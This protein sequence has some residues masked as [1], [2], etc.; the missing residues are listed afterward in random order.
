MIPLRSGLSSR[1]TETVPG[2]PFDGLY[3][4]GLPSLNSRVPR[5]T[6]PESVNVVDSRFVTGKI[7]DRLAL[8]FTRYY[9]RE[10]IGVKRIHLD[11]GSVRPR[12]PVR[13]LK[14]GY[15]RDGTVWMVRNVDRWGGWTREISSPVQDKSRNRSLG[16]G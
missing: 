12:S 1:G 14:L 6:G 5:L 7:R 3:K 11:F 4:S 15:V 16:S 10:T 2:S 13:E 9:F 8:C